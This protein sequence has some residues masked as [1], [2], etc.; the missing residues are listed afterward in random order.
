MCAGD[1]VNV[2]CRSELTITIYQVN[3]KS[4]SVSKKLSATRAHHY[5]ATK[6][7]RAKC[8]T[9]AHT[10]ITP[11]DGNPQEMRRCHID[12]A[13]K[14][15]IQA[16]A[17]NGTRPARRVA[18]TGAN[19]ETDSREAIARPFGLLGGCER[20]RGCVGR[21]C[22][23][24]ER[25]WPLWRVWRRDNTNSRGVRVTCGDLQAERL[26]ASNPARCQSRRCGRDRARVQGGRDVGPGR[27]FSHGA[28]IGEREG[29]VGVGPGRRFSQ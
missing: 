28:H 7:P 25:L 18:G 20:V 19:G 13:L 22:A 23:R 15:K 9:R 10:G 24:V 14:R 27:R 2:E 1:V 6:P 11:F 8:R 5:R 29:Q 4:E 26:R 21:D 16:G 3:T 12:R 17:V